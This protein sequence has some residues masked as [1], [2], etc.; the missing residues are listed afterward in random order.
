MKKIN[1]PSKQSI[2][3]V[4]I[5]SVIIG[6]FFF[7][8][9]FRNT[10]EAKQNAKEEGTAAFEACEIS[11]KVAGTEIPLDL[12]E[13]L[14]GVVA[15]EMPANFNLEA[16]KAQAIASR[17]YVVKSTNYGEQEIAPTVAR[18]VFYDEDTRKENWKTSFEEYEQKVREA[19]ESTKGEVILYNGEPITAMFHSTS[20]GMTESSKNY[21]GNDLP[22]LQPVASSDYQYAPNYES[23][24]SFKINEFNNLLK[25]NWTLDDVKKIKI[26]Q[27]DTGRVEKVALKNNEW[28]G[29]E[30]RELLNLRSTDFK[31]EVK[32]GQ[33]VIT[34]EGYG[35]GVGMSQYGAD[36]MA[37]KGALAHEILQHYYSNTTINKLSC[38][39]S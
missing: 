13:Y 3:V 27:N 37:A 6:L 4:V 16:L 8:F 26:E 34:T 23:T 33:V 24:Q 35:H 28:T 25:G 20:N 17:T 14:I 19:V 38:Q 29:R 9:L 5:T 2:H 31:V 32:D 30:F 22:Y 21:G 12:E 18:Q 1:L 10:P 15:A 39:K 36:A 11:I 7:P